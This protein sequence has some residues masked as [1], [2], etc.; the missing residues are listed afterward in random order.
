MFGFLH[1]RQHKINVEMLPRF[2]ETVMLIGYNMHCFHG[3]KANRNMIW[4]FFFSCGVNENVA[5]VLGSIQP[6]I[7]GGLAGSFG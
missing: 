5:K 1:R 2:A 7:S 6:S 4:L 3:L